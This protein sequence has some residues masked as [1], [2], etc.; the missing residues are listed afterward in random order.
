MRT[1]RSKVRSPF[2]SVRSPRILS[3]AR[4]D[5]A[6]LESATL[7]EMEQEGA[8]RQ[9]GTYPTFRPEWGRRSENRRARYSRLTNAGRKQLAQEIASYRR[10]SDAIAPILGSVS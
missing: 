5:P 1:T 2:T 6:E 3:A 4:R 10:V 9:K 7:V 8:R